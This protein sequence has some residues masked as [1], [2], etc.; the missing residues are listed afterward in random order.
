MTIEDGSIYGMIYD[1]NVYK[2]INIYNSKT[3]K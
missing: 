1:I 2:Y 3:N